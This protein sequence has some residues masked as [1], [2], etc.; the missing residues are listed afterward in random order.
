MVFNQSYTPSHPGI[1]WSR[2]I[3]L[4]RVL[5][6]LPRTNNACPPIQRPQHGR[7]IHPH[8]PLFPHPLLA[9]L[10]HPPLFPSRPTLHPIPVRHPTHAHSHNLGSIRPTLWPPPREIRTLSASP[11]HRLCPRN[12]RNGSHD[13]VTQRFMYG[14]MGRLPSDN[15]SRSRPH[16]HHPPCR[17][18]R[19]RRKRRRYRDRNMGISS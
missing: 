4:L 15:S 3:R 10:L 1:S 2:G 5:Q 19:P 8:I 11:P 9:R 7:S 18:R 12:D 13:F 17:P 16:K 14:T 6:I